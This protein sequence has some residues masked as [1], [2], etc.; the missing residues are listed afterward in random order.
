MANHYRNDFSTIGFIVTKQLQKHHQT[1]YN[2]YPHLLY[3]S[4]FTFSKFLV[5]QMQEF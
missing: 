4:A 3:I 2:S 1:K 5:S